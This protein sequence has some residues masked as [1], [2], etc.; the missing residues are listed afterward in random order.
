MLALYSL[1]QVAM[2]SSLSEED[3][4]CLGR[5]LHASRLA[6]IKSRDEAS[7]SQ[8]APFPFVSLLYEM[9]LYS[10]FKLFAHAWYVCAKD[11]RE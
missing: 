1:S 3:D 8:V 11:R 5:L 7:V 6:N 4:F 9:V 10:V 2:R